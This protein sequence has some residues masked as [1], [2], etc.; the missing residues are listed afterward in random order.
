MFSPQDSQQRVAAAVD[1]LAVAAAAGRNA[2]LLA[3]GRPKSGKSHTLAGSPGASHGS[4]TGAGAGLGCRCVGVGSGAPQTL[5]CEPL[6]SIRL[7]CHALGS[8][9]SLGL[10][11]LRER[12][13]QDGPSPELR[14]T[15]LETHHPPRVRG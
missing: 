2:T 6:I 1:R 14:Q 5:S 4:P 11:W 12:Q 10:A 7:M 13:Q 15:M 8:R 3:M 9:V